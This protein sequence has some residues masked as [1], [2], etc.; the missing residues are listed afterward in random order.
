MLQSSTQCRIFPRIFLYH[1]C[2]HHIMC[3]QTPPY[4]WHRLTQHSG[5]R[6]RISLIYYLVVLTLLK[7]TRILSVCVTVLSSACPAGTKDGYLIMMHDEPLPKSPY[8]SCFRDSR[9]R[10]A[11]LIYLN[12]Y[13]VAQISPVR[14]VCAASSIPPTK[15]KRC[16]EMRPNGCLAFAESSS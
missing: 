4:V 16:L 1:P 8:V 3:S 14:R 5:P 6:I 11:P 12:F 13:F 15:F 2:Y 9:P 7:A 10:V